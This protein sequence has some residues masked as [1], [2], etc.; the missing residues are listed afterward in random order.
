MRLTAK[1]NFDRVNFG[2]WQIKTWYFSPYPVTESEQDDGHGPQ[3]SDPFKAARNADRRGSGIHRTT[4]RA[5]GRTA[6]LVAGGLDRERDEQGYSTLW[7]CDRCFK[8]MRDG[9]QWEVHTRN[10]NVRHPPGRKVYERGAHVIWEVDG[11]EEK[12]YCQNLSLFG[13]LFIDIK[14]LFFDT[15]NFMFYLLTDADSQRDHVLGFF[16]KEKVSYDNYNLACIVTLPPYQRKGYGMLLIE[17]S[18]ELSRRAGVLGTP[19]RP[20][21][22]LGLRSYVTFW[23][24]VLV[25]FFRR[26][27]TAGIADVS[28]IQGTV[29]EAAEATDTIQKSSRRKRIKPATLDGKELVTSFPTGPINDTEAPFFSQFR[30]T[31]TFGNPD[32]SATTHV[33]VQCTLDDVSK[34]TALRAAD[35]AFA[36]KECGLLQRRK[37]T[38]NFTNQPEYENGS[39]NGGG[40]GGSQNGKREESASASVAGVE[41]E[42]VI[43]ISREMVEAVAKARGVKRNMMDLVCVLL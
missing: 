22:D 4:L 32:G 37:K 9:V 10:C 43:C 3:T 35:A 6:D 15:E 2:H 27:L 30:R 26:V 36:L 23:I 42:D 25:R 34:A 24:S 20:L 11:A 1:R 29:H 21:S 41:Y 33:V 40:G 13:K 39:Q 17:F 31:Q 18:Y 7:V 8:Y 12:L 16:S 28:H 5:H 19:E 38:P 14:T